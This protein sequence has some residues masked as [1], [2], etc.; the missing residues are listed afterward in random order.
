MPRPGRLHKVRRAKYLVR[1]QPRLKFRRIRS[2]RAIIVLP[3]RT[4]RAVLP[5]RVVG[6]PFTVI[7]KFN[8]KL[9]ALRELATLGRTGCHLRDLRPPHLSNDILASFYFGVDRRELFER[10]HFPF[11]R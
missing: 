3:T 5:P 8:F 4:L 2:T 9:K 1:A 7:I 10:G 6:E 11:A